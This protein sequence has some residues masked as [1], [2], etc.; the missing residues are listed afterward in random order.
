[1]SDDTPKEDS[2]NSHHWYSKTLL[3]NPISLIGTALAGVA[4]VNILFLFLIDV[5]ASH[6][7]P[8]IGILA[9]MIAPGFLVL[10][11]LLIPV[12]VIVERRRRVRAVGLTP[13]LPK[14]DLHQRSQ[15]STIAFL[16]SFV[17]FF[18]LVSAVGSYK[19]YE[20]TDSVDFCGELCHSVM[21]PE[22]VAYQI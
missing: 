20:F 22:F 12:G 13:H 9:Y 6:A 21:N 1:M 2:A 3:R 5:L 15:R 10:G 18:M 7:S 16:L 14:N 8:Y 19:A 4:F 17:V 11:L